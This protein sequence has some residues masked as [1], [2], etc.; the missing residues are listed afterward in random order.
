MTLIDDERTAHRHDEGAAAFQALATA[1]A[2]WGA[3]R[4][5]VELGLPDL[6]PD[7]PTSVPDLAALA[8]AAPTRLAQLVAVLADVGVL[9]LDERAHVRH[10]PL[11]RALRSTDGLPLTRLLTAGWADE[12]WR[13]LAEGV[14]ADVSPL[15]LVHGRPLFALL[16][17]DPAAAEVFHEA[18]ATGPGDPFDEAIR[19]AL[20]LT[21]AARVADVG[22]G[23]G[24][25][26]AALLREHP[27]LSGVLFDLPE[28]VRDAVPEL[29]DDDRVEIRAGDL[30]AD[31]VGAAD[32][33]VLRTVLH[34]LDDAQAVRALANVRADAPAHARVVVVEALSDDEAHRT[35]AAHSSLRLFVLCG[36]RERSTAEFAELFD[37]AGLELRSVTPT[38][39]P[40]H[41]LEGAPRLSPRTDG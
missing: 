5:A 10:T 38:G 34:V 16:A 9:A 26:L 37:R 31:R 30:F 2:G 24:R 12:A 19:S 15:E 32:V 6:L 22:G 21:G 29:R 1:A 36:G 39:T 4:A 35:Y 28:A 23:R 8:G 20:D 40:Y 13:G 41:L 7:A 3:L 18:V 17:A 27:G 11:S 25:L 33:Y 14:R